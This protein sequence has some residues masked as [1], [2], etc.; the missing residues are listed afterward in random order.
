MSP[1]EFRSKAK[2]C[3]AFTGLPMEEWAREVGVNIGTV[4]RWESGES[5][6]YP[7]YR[8]AMVLLMEQ[9]AQRC[10]ARKERK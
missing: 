8:D 6:P 3:R 10:A 1:E 9:I 4:S 5:V 7:A 2:E